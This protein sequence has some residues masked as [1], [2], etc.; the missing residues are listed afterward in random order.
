MSAELPQVDREL[1]DYF[2]VVFGID[3]TGSDLDE[4]VFPTFE[5]AIGVL[6]L[7]AARD[8]TFRELES[9]KIRLLRHYLVRLMTDVIKDKLDRPNSYHRQLAKNLAKSGEISDVVVISTNYDTLI[10]NSLS[11]IPG[12]DVD[13]GIEFAEPE[14]PEP[15]MAAGNSIKL[16]KLHGSLNWMYCPACS[17]VNLAPFQMAALPSS[18]S[19]CGSQYSTLIVPPTYFKN[20]SNVHLGMVWNQA[21][22][23]L[24]EVQHLIFCGYSFPEAD[25]HIKYL[26]KRIQTHYDGQLAITVVNNYSG[27]TEESITDEKDRY[28][29]CLGTNVNYTD[30][31]FEEFASDW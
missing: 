19:R 17:T 24:R 7:A 8:E 25:M 15:R 3:V 26:I 14:R 13:Y 31:S 22:L 16:Y 6:D 18:C 1:R 23:A 5:E 28:Q 30:I 12:I 29:R 27:K 10:D 9:S 21:E 11:F 4:T 2:Q 20:I